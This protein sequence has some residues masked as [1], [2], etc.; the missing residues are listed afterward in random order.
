MSTIY[1]GKDA[2]MTLELFEYQY[3]KINQPEFKNLKYVME[4]IEMPLLPILE[5]MQRNGVN[6]NNGMLDELY[7]KYNER[8]IKAEAD[9]YTEIDKHKEEIDKYR[10]KHYNCKLDDPIKI[11]SPVQLS[12][13]FYDILGYKSKSGKGT[14]VDELQEIGSDLTNALLEYRKMAKLIDAFLVALPK[15][16]EPLDGKIHTNLNQYRCRNRK[17]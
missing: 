17:V 8:L 9:V 16:I 4:N 11:S 14:G 12:I 13:L 1:A 7:R 6:I 5:D 3:N 15:R 10:L 2:F